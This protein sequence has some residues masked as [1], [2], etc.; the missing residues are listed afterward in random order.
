[1]NICLSV[2][3][4]CLLALPAFAAEKG[5]KN[6]KDARRI[7]VGEA[8]TRALTANPSIHAAKASADAA[9]AG[10]KSARGLFGPSLSSSYGYARLKQ[11][12]EPITTSDRSPEGGI[13]TWNVAVNQKLFTGFELLSTYQK[14]ALQAESQE[15]NLQLTKL[16]LT[17]SVQNAFFNYLQAVDNVRSRGDSLERLRLQL[18]I[19][20]ASFDVGLRPKLDVLQA[21]VNVSD[22]EGLLIAAEN[23]RETY[24]AQLNTLIGEPVTADF[25]YVGALAPVPFYTALEN[26]LERSYR[27]RPDLAIA[28]K[29]TAIAGKDVKIVQSQY[30]PQVSGYYSLTNLGDNLALRHAHRDGYRATRWE[31]GVQAAWA[32]FEWGRTFYADRQARFTESQIRANEASL[33]LNAG[34]DVKSKLLAVRDAEKIIAVA[35]KGVEQA[36]EAYKQAQ[37]RYRA[38]VGTN[39]DVLDA[40]ANLAAAETALIGAKADYLTALSALYVSM[41]EFKPDL[42]GVE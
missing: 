12:S 40:S 17:A 15:L 24:R 41:G 36:T 7:T 4:A 33:K 6:G 28:A 29:A 23:A 22:A 13:F 10:R 18:E 1:M 25:E 38:Q 11:E 19:T 37:A 8:V 20:K 5:I 3:L 26:C 16:N 32:V 34:F 30:Y 42:S 35:Q 31:V 39:F 9:E 27:Q 21:E 14:A 2:V